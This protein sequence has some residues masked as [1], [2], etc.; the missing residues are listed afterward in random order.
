V[1]KS[2]RQKLDTPRHFGRESQCHDRCFAHAPNYRAR[3]GSVQAS[4]EAVATNVT[5]ET[6]ALA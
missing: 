2:P 4:F 5:I 3:G 1:S 6:P